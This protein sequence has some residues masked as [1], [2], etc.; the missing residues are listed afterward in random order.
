MKLAI[1]KDVNDE[2]RAVVLE[3]D[4]D[5]YKERLANIAY[6][7]YVGNKLKVIDDIVKF[8]ENWIKEYL[9]DKYFKLLYEVND[10][11]IKKILK[12]SIDYALKTLENELKKQT[13]RIL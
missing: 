3:Y 13:V 10:D 4:L 1:I 9:I 8:E 5:T 2:R 6:E 11:I 12:D 7:Y